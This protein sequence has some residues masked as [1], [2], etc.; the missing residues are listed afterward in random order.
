MRTTCLTGV[1]VARASPPTRCVGE[2]AVA[3]SG[4]LRLEIAQ[5]AEQRVEDGVAHLGVVEDV[6]AVVVGVDLARELGVTLGGG[7]RE[8]RG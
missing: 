3:S 7:H 1:A 2:C 8:A 6:V 4:A 5:L